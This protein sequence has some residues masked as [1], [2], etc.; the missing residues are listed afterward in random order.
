MNLSS[1]AYEFF[2]GWSWQSRAFTITSNFSKLPWS[3]EDHRPSHSA[4]EIQ[5]EGEFR[6]RQRRGRKKCLE[7]EGPSLE[8]PWEQR[9]GGEDG[10]REL[11]TRKVVIDELLIE[12]RS[13]DHLHVLEA[14][15]G[16]LT[17][18]KREHR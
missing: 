11:E 12:G 10:A 18:P 5:E 14:A 13:P 2:L 7:E 1:K 4:S 16:R 17:H 6:T 3:V 9:Y 15:L 8:R